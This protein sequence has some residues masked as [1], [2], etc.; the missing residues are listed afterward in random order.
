MFWRHPII[1]VG[2][3]NFYL[4]Y[5]RDRLPVASEEIRDPHNFIIRFFVEL[6][7]IGGILM[8]A[9]L[10]PGTALYTAYYWSPDRGISYAR[11]ILTLVPAVMLVCEAV[12]LVICG[13][14]PV[15]AV[16]AS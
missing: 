4:H 6:G 1:G 11:F 8:L 10:I 12:K 14:V 5:L 7:A 13:A 2:W 15:G 16:T 3:D 9:W